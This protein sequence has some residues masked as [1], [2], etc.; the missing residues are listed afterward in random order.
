MIVIDEIE[1]EGLGARAGFQ[2]GD[3]LLRINGREVNDLIDFQVHSAEQFLEIEVERE[4]EIYLV[5]LEREPGDSFGLSFEDMKLRRCNNNCV[6]CF[7]HQMPKGMRHTLYFEDDDYRL[8]FLH[9]SYVTL[10]NVKEEDLDRIVEQRLS[11]QYISVHTTDPELRQRMLGRRRPVVDIRERIGKL[12]RG[13]I[14]M[15]T[16]VVLCPGWNDGPHLEQTVREL[17]GYYPGV[18]SV[19]LVPVGLTRFR[20][21]Q[22]QLEPVTPARALE[23]VC[24]AEAWGAEYSRDLGER[25]VYAADEFFLL[26]GREPPPASYYDAFPQIEN[27]IGMTR[28]FLDTWAQN[29]NRLPGQLPR[30]VRL[31]IVT[32]MLASRFLGALVDQLGQIGGLVAEL[33]PVA[34]DFFGH[35][36]T[37]SG[38][39]TGADIVRHLRNRGPWDMVLLPPNCIN[40]EGLTLDNMT[41]PQLQAEAGVPLAV[42]QYDLAASVQGVLEGTSTSLRGDGRQ[43]SELGYY[44]GRKR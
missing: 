39:L 38:L 14:E 23:Y 9:G 13:G 18:R 34:N 35:G 37:V 5:E 4:G 25:F 3:R 26:I 41:V 29:R 33:I 20:Q 6:F 43:L 27:G 16:Q 1:K 22:P 15:H 21:N 12:A 30:T 31:G 10:T 7:I 44:L 36:I 8:S 40:G 17:N 24:Q 11:P 32:G 2:R 42:G 19:A 28:S